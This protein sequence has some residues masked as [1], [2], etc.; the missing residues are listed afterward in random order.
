MRFYCNSSLCS[1]EYKMP[2][3]FLPISCLQDSFFSNG[4]QQWDYFETVEVILLLFAWCLSFW[5][6]WVFESTVWCVSLFLWNFLPLSLK[7]FL[8]P[9]S[10]MLLLLHQIDVWG[11][12]QSQ[13]LV[14]LCLP[15]W[16][17][18]FFGLLLAFSLSQNHPVRACGESLWVSADFPCV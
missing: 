12:V 14:P 2:F 9:C 17:R 11:I 10:L 15:T 4:F 16:R 3:P 13:P 6:L 5:V 8:L 7:I 18:A 1:F